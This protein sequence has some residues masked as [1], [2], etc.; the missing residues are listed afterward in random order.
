V[1]PSPSRERREG[2]PGPEESRP[3]RYRPAR[4]QDVPQIVGIHGNAFPGFFLTELGPR[5]LRVLYA[6]M[7]GS[8]D[9]VVIVAEDERLVGFVAGA[10][11]QA[12][13]YRQLR[14]RHLVSFGSAAALATVRNPGWAF[15]LLRAIGRPG[16]AASMPSKAC[17]MSIAVNPLYQASGAGSQLVRQFEARLIERGCKDYCLTTDMEHN[18]PVRKF[19]ERLGLSVV[20]EITTREGRRMLEY[21]KRLAEE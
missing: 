10:P 3:L 2:G 19:Y 5:F 7:V 21:Y 20:R 16:E 6:G 8:N 15:R 11:D 12:S 14:N 1:R 13:L 18:A 4:E 17:M 9:G